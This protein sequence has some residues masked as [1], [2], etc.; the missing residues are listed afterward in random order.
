MK[1]GIVGFGK[2]GIG[3]ASVLREVGPCQYDIVGV[4]VSPQRWNVANENGFMVTDDYETLRGAGLIFVIV[5]TAFDEEY[6]Y[7]N[8]LD[9]LK[10]L[11]RISCPL[12]ISSTCEPRFFAENSIRALYNPL[13][14]RQGQIEHDIRHADL[15]LIGDDHDMADPLVGIYR[16]L[17]TKNIRRMSIAG[18][19]ITKLAI[20]TFLANKIAFANMVG[21]LCV[22][23][24]IAPQDVLWAVGSD[25][26]INPRYLEYGY[27]YGGPCLPIDTKAMQRAL[28]AFSLCDALPR[29]IDLQND[30]HL[31]FQV[32]HFVRTH[33]ERH[34][35]WN[36]LGYKENSYLLAHSQQLEMARRLASRGFHVVLHGPQTVLE[37]L[38]TIYGDIFS[39]ESDHD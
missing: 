35:D 5:N 36:T 21:D 12:V 10:Q 23:S 17:G 6:R 4:D 37:D 1:I 27:G 19:A 20:N 15:V 11:H 8:L 18:A 7:D 24:G 39:Y 13:F 3:L 22:A 9:A 38:F 2:V 25:S 33:T 16:A 28:A 30:F 26:R 31:T 32:E 14:I 29:I 34:I